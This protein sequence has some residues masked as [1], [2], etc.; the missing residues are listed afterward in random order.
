[1]VNASEKLKRLVLQC[2]VKRRGPPHTCSK[3]NTGYL[4]CVIEF[5]CVDGAIRGR[6]RMWNSVWNGENKKHY[7]WEIGISEYMWC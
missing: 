4:V 5:I 2:W 1:M 6:L 3:P 7:S